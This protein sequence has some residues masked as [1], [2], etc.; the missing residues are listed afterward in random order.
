L[1]GIA[2]TGTLEAARVAA[3]HPSAGPPQTHTAE[4]G[5]RARS[6]AL[7]KAAASRCAKVIDVTPVRR[8]D[9]GPKLT[10]VWP[11]NG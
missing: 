4:D 8:E 3:V 7:L 10:S 5:E 11:V 6:G 9:A 2:E 1:G